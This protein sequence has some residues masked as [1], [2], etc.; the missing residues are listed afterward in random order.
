MII[1]FLCVQVCKAYLHENVGEAV[2]DRRHTE[3]VHLARAISVRDL[4]QQVMARC[5]EGIK[6]LSESWIQLQFWLKT[7]HAK[8]KVHY[9]GKLDVRF[10]VQARQFRKT[11]CDSHY[12][13][14][15]FRYEREYA[16]MFKDYCSFVCL[17]DKHRIK[18]GEPE[19]PGAAV[20]RGRKVIVSRNSS[21]DVADHDFTKF[22]IVPSVCFFVDIPDS[23]EVSWQD[24]CWVQRRCF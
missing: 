5:P 11:H 14:A 8:S 7:P 13:A 1:L 12:A 10:M 23:I 6:V 16:I 20:E 9:T 21:F 24:F 3:V 2:D 17:D 22:S 19:Y 15:L 4:R 18:I